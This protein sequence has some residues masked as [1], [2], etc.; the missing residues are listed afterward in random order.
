MQTIDGGLS[1]AVPDASEVLNGGWRKRIFLVPLAGLRTCCVASLLRATLLATLAA[2]GLNGAISSAAP[3]QPVSDQIVRIGLLLDLSS[4]LTYVTGEGSIIA[5]RMAI[6]DFGDKVLGYP[7]EVVS[8]DH[9]NLAY[10][11][12]EQASAWFDVDNVDALMDVATTSTAL[13]VARIAKLKNRIVVF[14]TAASVRLTN[15]ACTP[16]TAHWTY[17]TYAL[18]HITGAEIVRNG[19]DTWYFVTGDYSYGY[20]LEKDT[21]EVVRA[22]GGKILGSTIHAIAIADFAGAHAARPPLRGQS[23]RPGHRGRGP[24]GGCQGGDRGRHW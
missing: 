11:A 14:N 17:D 22:A 15:E 20:T 12:A 10:V 5:A 23:D 7:I 4:P 9:R 3:D 13:A 6:E 1:R 2:T 19:G 16:V 21:A 24:F 8:A 18:A